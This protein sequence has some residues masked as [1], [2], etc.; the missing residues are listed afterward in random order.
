MF[1]KSSIAR[2]RDLPLPILAGIERLA[3]TKA[4]HLSADRAGDLSD[5]KAAQD[6]GHMNPDQVAEALSR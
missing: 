6:R 3:S 2:E 4:H 1:L 5:Q